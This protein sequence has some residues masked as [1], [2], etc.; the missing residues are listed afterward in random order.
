[1]EMNSPVGKNVLDAEAEQGPVGKPLDRVDGHL[2]VS[3][4]ARYAYEMAQGP[5]TTYGFIVQA[6]I[7]K[8][9]IKAIDTA[10]AEKAPGVVLVLTHLNAPEQG[11]GTHA[12]AHPVLTGP[13]VSYYGEPVAL[14]VAETFEQ[15]RAAAF[16]VRVSYDQEH[17]TYALHDGLAEAA[18]PVVPPNAP[19]PDTAVGDFNAAFA[20][21]PVQVDVTYTT[22]LQTH[23]MMEPHASLAQWDGDKLTLHTANQQLNQS[24]AVIAR[25]LKIPVENVRLVAPFIGGGFGGKLWVG[26]DAILSAIAA[27]KLGRPVKTGL[28]RQQVFQVTTHR[29]DTIQRIRLGTDQDGKI[30]AIGHDVISGNLRSEPRY[31]WAALQTRTLYAGANRQTRHKRVPLDVPVAS[32]MRAPGESVGLLALECAM[33]E[34]AEK[35]GLDPIELRVRNEPTE[36][37][38]L[39]IPYSSRTL[40]PCFREG[41]KRFGWDKRNKKPGQVR[42]GQWLVGMGVAS[43]TRGN[44]LLPSQAKVRLDPNGVATVTMAMTD[45]GTGTYTIMTQIA[46]EMLGLKMEQVKVLMGD[47]DYPPAAGSGGSYGAGSAGSALFDA[48]TS[49]RTKL[50][51]AAGMD[52]SAVRF[53]NGQVAAGGQSRK[54]TDLVGAGMEADGAIVPGKTLKDYSQ[55]S[56]GA[57]FAEVG[58]DADTGE[59]RLRRML[60]VFTAGRILNEKT[61]RSQAIGGMIFGLGGALEE[62]LV[63]DPRFGYYVNHDLAEYA[64]PVHADVP[65]VDAIFLP[66]LDPAANPLKAKGVGELG[67]CGAGA[68]I[69]NAVYNACGVRV[70][71]YPI[72]LDKVLAGLPVQA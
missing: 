2:K 33:D 68:A 4:G 8:G 69:A 32:S 49:L 67:I 20:Q 34:L 19:P 57:H 5:D 39:H 37:P 64:V 29:S 44:P 70:R 10:S 16:L 17:G 55:Q 53:A 52:P 46:A 31:E 21:A 25:T 24:R 62:E 47:T 15:A 13:E 40:V 1:M 71:D 43:A 65:H 56:Y 54:L 18:T 41:A 7:G 22:P 51:L 36:D 9:R 72:T 12:V 26:A 59:I 48:C 28:T 38:E 58:V 45:I 61:A 35:L 14:V 66:E 50:A 27:R 23:A 3:G 60:G 63:L 30:L 42:D 6:S 11:A